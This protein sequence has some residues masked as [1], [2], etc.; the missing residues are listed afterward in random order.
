[1]LLVILSSVAA[2]ISTE[3]DDLL[4]LFIL[5]GAARNSRDKVAVT[6]G[7]YLGLA[8]LCVCSAVFASYISRVPSH[9]L[10]LLGVLPLVIGIKEMIEAFREGNKEVPEKDLSGFAF[11][12]LLLATLI[13]TVA[14][15]GDNI[16]VYIPYFTSL[17]LTGCIVTAVVFILLQ[18]AFCGLAWFVVDIDSV[19]KVLSRIKKFLV[20]L[21]FLFLG[22][23]IMWSNGS[24][25]W[26]WGVMNGTL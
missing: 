10:G 21:L 23:F 22:I 1:M 2:F 11:L 19:K 8:L 17:N 24:F 20:P 4:S 15:G 9:W 6:I 3:V 18:G 12:R 5:M 26:L 13:V 14:D 16:A 25:S 7:K